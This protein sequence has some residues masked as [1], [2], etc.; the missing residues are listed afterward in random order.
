MLVDF[1]DMVVGPCVQDL[2]LLVPGRDEEALRHR[3]RM[4][5]AYE[6]MRDFDRSQLRLIEPLRAMRVVHFSAWIARR[7]EDPAFPRVF[8]EFGTE[9]YWFEELATLREIYAAILESAEPSQ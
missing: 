1:D 2:W 4:V 8:P 6:Q 9:R 5:E 7:W 3:R